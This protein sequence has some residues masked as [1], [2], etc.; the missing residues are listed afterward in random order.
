MEN[1]GMM[2]EAYITV[3]ANSIYADAPKGSGNIGGPS[4]QYYY[5]VSF[6]LGA[7]NESGFSGNG[8]YTEHDD[9]PFKGWTEES[10]GMLDTATVQEKLKSFPNE[11]A[12]K[13]FV[14][15]LQEAVPP[16]IVEG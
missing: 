2:G 5:I 12:T 11:G 10:L 15:K 7:D 8:W 14:A 16:C 1:M 9:S 4:S 13:R 6:V 3:E